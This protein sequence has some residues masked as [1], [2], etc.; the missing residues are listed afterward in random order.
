MQRILD[1]FPGRRATGRF[2]LEPGKTV[3]G[4]LKLQGIQT[5]LDLH[6]DDPFVIDD[7]PGLHICGT[8]HG[9]DKVALLD[10]VPTRQGAMSATLAPQFVVFGPSHVAPEEAPVQSLGF[11]IDD[12]AILFH[13]CDA[14]GTLVDAEAYITPIVKATK[15]EREVATGPFP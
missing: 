6:D 1:R 7:R 8:L 4:D 12:A 13:G 14:F 11:V 3:F 15:P 9:F 10:C 2:L 5:S